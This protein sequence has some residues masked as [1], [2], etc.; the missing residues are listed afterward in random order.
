MDL[1]VHQ[2]ML[3]IALKQADSTLRNESGGTGADLSSFK[4]LWLGNMLTDLNQGTAFFDAVSG[5]RPNPYDVTNEDGDYVPPDSL[6]EVAAQWV[7]LIQIVWENDWERTQKAAG[8]SA[9]L[10][11]GLGNTEKSI[12]PTSLLDIG[13][14]NPLDHFDVVDGFET[15]GS[16]CAPIRSE[17][18]EFTAQPVPLLS[19][20]AYEGVYGHALMQMRCLF[21]RAKGN[22]NDLRILGRALHT[23]QD[24][25]GHSNYVE[26]LILLAAKQIPEVGARLQPVFLRPSVD[27]LDYLFYP[28]GEEALVR[29][30][31]VTGRF[32]RADTLWT[33]LG[34]LRNQLIPEQDD[35]WQAGMF[36]THASDQEAD[37]DSHHRLTFKILFG[38]FSDNTMIGRAVKSLKWID[39][40]KHVLDD[41][42]AFL[43][44]GAIAIVE[45]VAGMFLEKREHR[46]LLHDLSVLLGAPKDKKLNRYLEVGRIDFAR[47]QI[48]RGLREGALDL[49]RPGVK[50]EELTKYKDELR[51]LIPKLMTAEHCKKDFEDFVKRAKRDLSLTAPRLLPHHT[52]LAKDHDSGQ[53]EQRLL[54]KIACSLATDATRDVLVHYFRGDDFSAV[55]NTLRKYYQHPER[56]LAEPGNRARVAHWVEQLYGVRWYQ[57]ALP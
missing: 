23:L 12:Q 31:V 46:S 42:T 17:A 51:G 19:R 16:T 10:L 13:G 44:R 55:E 21:P 54:Y 40:A 24:F 50:S 20:T 37:Y 32:D 27:E 49:A 29:T 52:V 35:L 8:E 53:P 15:I 36:P 39:E 30:P 4:A 3:A 25:F 6:K 57:F 7:N 47:A 11:A 33:L 38:T 28:T 56:F 22:P 26:L 34:I 1:Q 18:E 41:V 43:H 48:V 2:A 45:E 9:S 14:Y 5:T